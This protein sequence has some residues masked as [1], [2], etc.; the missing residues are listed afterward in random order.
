MAASVEERKRRE[1]K[2]SIA[3]NNAIAE[4]GRPSKPSAGVWA[5]GA[6][7]AP[8]QF[9]CTCKYMLLYRRARRVYI[10]PAYLA[11]VSTLLSQPPPL[12]AHHSTLFIS[13]SVYNMGVEVPSDPAPNGYV[14]NPHQEKIDEALRY[15]RSEKQGDT[16]DGIILEKKYV[17]GD[18]SAIPIV[19]GHGLVKDLSAQA[20]LSTILQPSARHL[21]DERFASGALLERYGRRTYKFY[22]VQKGVGW[23]VSERDIVGVQHVQDGENGAFEVVQTSVE[24]DPDNSGRVR[25]TLTC[26][27]WSVVPRGN[28]LEVIVQDIP[29]AVVNITNFIRNK[30]VPPYITNQDLK[31][32]LRTEV[33]DVEKRHHE[34]RLIAGDTD[35]ELKIAVDPKLFGGNWSVGV[36][37]DG[38]AAE[39]DGDNAVVKVPAGTGRYE[40]KID[41][42]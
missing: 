42:A 28:D 1:A 31:S 16:K 25:A 32:Q 37:G 11:I 19:R 21:W 5:G 41:A 39:K 36:T 6:T 2:Q 24:G 26:A 20:L 9:P 18:S 10:G 27:G 12:T 8:R 17:Q 29:L 15:L 34:I 22:S 38:V 23:L 35:E 30:G 33:V 14:S 3:L 13:L 40:V 7:A 4:S